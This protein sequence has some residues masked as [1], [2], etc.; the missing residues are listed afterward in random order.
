[1]NFGEAETLSITL[2]INK[3]SALDKKFS[4]LKISIHMLGYSKTRKRSK[5][6]LKFICGFFGE[7]DIFF[8]KSV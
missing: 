8:Q 5:T 3:R 1:M 7:N 4:S 2:D 6:C